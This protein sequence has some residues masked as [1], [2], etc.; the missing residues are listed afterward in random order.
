[1]FNHKC[2]LCGGNLSTFSKDKKRSFF[3]CDFCK[4]IQVNKEDYV[5]LD[6]E[7]SRYEQHRNNST[8]QGYLH[9]IKPVV[10]YIHENGLLKAKGLDFGAGNNP[11]ISQILKQDGYQIKIYDP[12]FHND[13]EVL[14]DTFDYI[15][16]CEV[17]E[18]FHNPKGEFELLFKLLNEKGKLIIM[19]HLYDD[20][21]DFSKWYYKNDITHV[22]FYTLDTFR[23]IL[24]NFG[25]TKLQ[26]ENRLIILEK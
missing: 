25:F 2:S 22:F 11:V 3:L 24:D 14:K 8:D 16:V 18:H 9:F 10:D 6:L 15:I 13:Q 23:Y 1:M 7:K 20:S 21:M 17:I 26:T 4:A 19:T 5:S 12:F